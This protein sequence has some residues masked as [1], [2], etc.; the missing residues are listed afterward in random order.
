MHYMSVLT[1]LPPR[2]YPPR[3]ETAPVIHSDVFE[4]FTQ[5]DTI[6]VMTQ[7][8]MEN[9]LNPRILDQLFDDV[10]DRQYTRE[11]L[12]SS[13][14][15][16]MSLVVCGIRPSIN[17]AYAKNAVPINVSLAALYGKIRRIETPIGSAMARATA[18][19]L[20]PVITAMGGGRPPL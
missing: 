15:E 17:A 20:A 19:R 11:L 16:L 13:L 5:G 12:S 10:A 2:S 6:P 8:L 18:E 7:A 1:C 14:V 3:R 4:R 9:A